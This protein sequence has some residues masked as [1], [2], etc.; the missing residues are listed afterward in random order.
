VTNKQ[1]RRKA[2]FTDGVLWLIT[3][4]VGIMFLL[5]KAVSLIQVREQEKIE[6]QQ[7]HISEQLLKESQLRLDY[8]G[9]D[10]DAVEK[11]NEQRSMQDRIQ[12]ND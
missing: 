1:I 6:Q 10:P 4:L 3:I 11:I 8:L 12:N 2:L 9:K 5:P 7:A